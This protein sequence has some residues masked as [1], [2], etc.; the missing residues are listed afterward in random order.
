MST[1]NIPVLLKLA[2]LLCAFA[3]NVNAAYTLDQ[4]Q[5]DDVQGW[6]PSASELETQTQ[7][8]GYRLIKEGNT[9]IGALLLTSQINPIPAYS[10]K[11]ISTLVAIT[12]DTRIAGLKIV[13]HEEP[14]LVVGVKETDISHFINQYLNLKNTDK[15]RVNASDRPGYVSVDGITGA[16]ITAMVLN[17]S[18][19]SSVEKVCAALQWPVQDTTAGERVNVVN[20]ELSLEQRWQQRADTWASQKFEAWTIVGALLLLTLILLFQDWLVR[21]P[22]LFR[23]LRYGFLIFT[24][25]FIG[26]VSSAQLSVVNILA[27]IQTIIHNFTWD[28]LMIDPV[29]FFLWSFVAISVLLWGRG[30]FCGW[31]CPFGAMQELIHDLASRLN[32]PKFE[33]SPMIHERLWALKYLILIVLVGISMDSFSTAAKLAEVEP[34]KTSLTMKFMRDWG[35]VTYAAG[36]LTIAAFNSKFFCKYLCALG[37]SLSI[38]GRFKIFDWLRRRNECGKPC[39]SCAARCQINAIKPTGGIV[40]NECHHCLE[41]QLI[42]WDEHNCPPLVEKRKKREKREANARIKAANLS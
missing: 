41:C 14:I 32:M 15:V 22:A 37:A 42:Y 11:P 7:E 34:F 35:Y 36:L 28:T 38:L 2:L 6:F 3:C 29:A 12:P 33:F 40:D 31:L 23:C 1:G 9:V 5:L 20:A 26:Y 19:M 30:V 24:V 17:R 16:T 13:Q 21:R 27:F 4:F 18:I 39:Q 25:I 10:G 8:P